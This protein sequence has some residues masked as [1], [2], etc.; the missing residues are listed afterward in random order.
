M[1]VAERIKNFI[2][3]IMRNTMKKRNL[4]LVMVINQVLGSMMVL[5]LELRIIN[6]RMDMW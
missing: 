6:I 4:N 3:T 2:L 5:I 1:T